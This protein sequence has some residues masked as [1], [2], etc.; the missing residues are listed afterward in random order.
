[1]CIRDRNPSKIAVPGTRKVLTDAEKAAAAKKF[2]GGV[3]PKGK[4]GGTMKGKKC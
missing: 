3:K 4:R 2:L 1:M